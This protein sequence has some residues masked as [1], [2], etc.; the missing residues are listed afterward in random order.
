V[1]LLFITTHNLVTNPRLTK[2]LNLAVAQGHEVHVLYF[3]FDNW[4]RTLNNSM[5]NSFNGA[6][7]FYP[8]TIGKKPLFDWLKATFL[9]SSG[10]LLTRLFP[11]SK[12][13]LSV[14]INKLSYYLVRNLHRL[15]RVDLAI[16]HNIGSFYPAMY[17]AS[18]N[19]TNY[20]LD[21]EDYHAG[22]QSNRGKEQ[23][24]A[25]LNKGTMKSA[26][27]LTAASP[28]IAEYTA[29]DLGPGY[30]AIQVINN[31]FSA[32]EFSSPNPS[33]R[34]VLKFVWFSQNISFGRGL[35]EL[36]PLLQQVMPGVELHLY[37]NLDPLFYSQHL[38]GFSVVHLHKPL[39]Q[40]EL[41]KELSLYDIGLAIEP[42]RDINNGIAISNKIN[43]YLQA[44][45]YILA[46]PTPAQVRWLDEKPSYGQLIPLDDNA[47]AITVLEACKSSLES[48]RKE[49]KSRYGN[50]SAFCWEEESKQ[51]IP[52]WS[53]NKS[54]SKNKVN[55]PI[56]EIR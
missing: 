27:Y 5:I 31:Y 37:G 29:K 19:K 9:H 34:P 13:L 36:V 22:E 8:I 20:A 33:T 12:Y 30:P 48:I 18:K 16:G 1:R 52:I 4:S 56:I 45:L 32:A 41:H 24:I 50:A 2:E 6:V 15:P 11:G 49:G 55:Q 51:L 43:A 53:G 54:S 42:N 39:L 28:L 26:N 7:F 38:E 44:G 40:Q 10:S 21:I 23:A 14:Y 17:Y 47:R 25:R 3:D 35:E 46:S